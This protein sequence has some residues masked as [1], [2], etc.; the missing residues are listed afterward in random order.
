M[1]MISIYFDDCLTIGTEEEI[2]EVINASICHNFGLKVEDNLTDYLS[3]KIDQERNKGKVWI[4]Q[5][6]LVDNLEKKFGGKVS[7]MQSY[8]TPGAPCF[9]FERHKNVLEVIE[10]KN[11]SR[12]RSGMGILLYLIKHSRPDIANVERELSKFTDGATLAEYKKHFKVI[13]FAVVL[14]FFENGI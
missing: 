3:C 5:P 2:E 14:S 7:K 6:H 13:R 12:F 8:T 10:A 4:M 1:I 9:K 11:Q